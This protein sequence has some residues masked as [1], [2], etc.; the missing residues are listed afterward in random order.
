MK[1]TPIC[2][3]DNWT[4]GESTHD[5]AKANQ[6]DVSVLYL[7]KYLVRVLTLHSRT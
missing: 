6:T 4:V 2:L 7:S 3:S 5:I 1:Y